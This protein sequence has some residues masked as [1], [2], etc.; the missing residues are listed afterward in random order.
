MKLIQKYQQPLFFPLRKEFMG[1]I[2]LITVFFLF[3]YLIRQL[4]VSA[5]AIDPGIISA[6]ILAAIAILVFKALTWWLI[7]VIWPVF[8]EYSE[9]QFESN[10]RSM[11]TGQKVII[12]LSFYLLILYAF[13]L[14][15]AALI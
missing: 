15:L 11:R 4:D 3:P 10:F 6:V 13:I 7:K 14:V 2:I 1:I 8:A 9:Q 5:A 12:Y